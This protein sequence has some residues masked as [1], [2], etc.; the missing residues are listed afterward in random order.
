MKNEITALVDKLNAEEA[1]PLPDFCA[2]REA[3]VE[4][5]YERVSKYMIGNAGAELLPTWVMATSKGQVVVMA[6]PFDGAGSKDVIAEAVRKFMRD[7]NVVRYAFTTEAWAANPTK[8][9]WDAGDKRPPSEREDRVE[10]VMIVAA[11]REGFTLNT[12]KIE[13]HDAGQ[14][15]ALS[16]WKDGKDMTGFTGRFANMLDEAA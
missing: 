15:T 16:L 2:S 3:M 14:V 8:E 7:A 13:R 10:I 11:D 5:E 1:R 6:T 12:Y 4:K 9:S